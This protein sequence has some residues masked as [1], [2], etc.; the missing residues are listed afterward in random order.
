[1]KI[2]AAGVQRKL[3]T[4]VMDGRAVFYGGEA[5]YAGGRL[6]DRLRSAGYGYTV[7]KN[8]GYAYLPL[9][10][11]AAGTQLEVESFGERFNAEVAADVLYDPPDARLR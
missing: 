6:V 7:E 8:I 9:P 3:C 5:V 1:M 10:L 4:L 2:K 11:T